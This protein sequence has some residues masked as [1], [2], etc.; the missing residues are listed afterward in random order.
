MRPPPGGR[1]KTPPGTPWTPLLSNRTLRNFDTQLPL[2]FRRASGSLVIG[3]VVIPLRL[4]APQRLCREETVLGG[5]IDPSPTGVD[6]PLKEP[7]I[8]LSL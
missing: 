3:A 5:R 8:R 2:N 4:T 7:R 6:S 1:V